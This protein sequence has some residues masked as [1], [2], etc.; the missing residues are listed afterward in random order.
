MAGVLEREERSFTVHAPH[1][2]SENVRRTG[3]GRQVMHVGQVM[4]QPH[5]P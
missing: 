3:Y 2:L 4:D 1:F 5:V